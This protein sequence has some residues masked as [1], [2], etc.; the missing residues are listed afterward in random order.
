VYTDSSKDIKY[1][2]LTF[3]AGAWTTA[4]AITVVNVD[5]NYN[6]FILIDSDG[7]Y[8]CF[9][10]NHNTSG[11]SKYYPRVKSSSDNGATWG[12]GPTDTG[13]ALSSG[14]TDIIYISALQI[15]SNIYAVFTV[16][17][18]DLYL[19]I[20][21][22]KTSS[23]SSQGTVHSGNYIDDDFDI[24]KSV[25]NKLGLTFAV[26]GDSKI[27][28]KEF[29][30]STWSGL[31]DVDTI[32]SRSPQIKYIGSSPKL[33]YAGLAG[34]NYYLLK[35]SELSQDTFINSAYS[36]GINVLDKLFV[37]SQNAGDYEDKTTNAS[38]I[39]TADIYH[40]GTTALLDIIDDCVY[41]GKS[42][43]FFCLSIILS[44]AGIGGTLVWEYYDG[45]QWNTF[46]PDS[47][48]Y[49]FDSTDKL[50]YLWEDI[51]STPEDWQ[52]AKINN[53][54]AYWVRVRVTVGFSVDPVG[55]QIIAVPKCDDLS[56]VREGA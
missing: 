11:D 2:K 24:A 50:V 31:Y 26:S 51:N 16:D 45:F 52:L 7:V 8:W 36:G 33:F 32:L 53:C 48:A 44:T 42:N 43:R 19:N 13:D 9:F 6:P 1:I 20:Y 12:T 30:G 56:L 35:Y 49:H 38:S 14:S 17:R 5:D 10:V 39:A 4:A 34:N 41:F 22:M 54:N 15:T 46:S 55:S 40:T 47:G 3:T 28:F 18:S 37:Y 25:D 29:N 27:Y 23:W 21:N